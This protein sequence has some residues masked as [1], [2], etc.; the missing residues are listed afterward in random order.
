MHGSPWPNLELMTSSACCIAAPLS[1]SASSFF[2]GS[3]FF[4]RL[5]AKLLEL[6][7]GSVM[8]L[9]TRWV[10]CGKEV[11]RFHRGPTTEAPWSD[12]TCRNAGSMLLVV[13][14]I[15]AGWEKQRENQ[16]TSCPSVGKGLTFQHRANS[17]E[18]SF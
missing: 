9:L 6:M 4:G 13:R 8:Q 3:C 16:L 7:H 1:A 17:N 10:D 15:A 2:T 11:R 5:L 14:S 12:K 18:R